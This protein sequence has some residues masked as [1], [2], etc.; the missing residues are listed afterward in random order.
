MVGD[1]TDLHP[2]MVISDK[3]DRAD[4]INSS[5]QGVTCNKVG[6]KQLPRVERVHGLGCG[7]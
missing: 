7:T 5:G 3:Y 6:D 4:V 1:S 2:G